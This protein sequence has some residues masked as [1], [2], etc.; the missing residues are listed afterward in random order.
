MSDLI[1]LHAPVTNRLVTLRPHAPW[2][3]EEDCFILFQFVTYELKQSQQNYTVP[4]SVKI[5][6]NIDNVENNYVK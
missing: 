6:C 4:P 2:Y 5:H 3:D 1:D